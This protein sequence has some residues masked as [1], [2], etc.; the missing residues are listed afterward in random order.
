MSPRWIALVM[1]T[2]LASREANAACVIHGARP[3]APLPTMLSGQEFSFIASPDCETLLFGIRGT[4]VSKIPK[5]GGPVGPGPHTYK[6]RLTESEWDAVVAESRS[7]LT[8]VVAGRTSTGVTTRMVTTNDVK[9]NEQITI[10][11]S[12]ADAK[13]VGDRPG[14]Y[15]GGSVSGAGDVDGD[16]R[17][18]IITAA[19][20]GL[21]ARV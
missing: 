4:T 1:G 5:S 19:G 15:A 18:D 6:V 16:G 13:L 2:L 9:R 21:N 17:D 7:T 3:T 12:T 8:W 10:D 20:A 11:L 14:D